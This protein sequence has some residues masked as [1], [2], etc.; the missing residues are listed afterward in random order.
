MTPRKKIIIGLALVFLIGLGVYVTWRTHNGSTDFDTY[1]YAGKDFL[2][3][4]SIYTPHAG[5]SPY[6][7]PPFFAAL[8]APLTVF[9]LEMAAALWYAMN[10]A[11]IFLTLF[12]CARMV[13]AGGHIKTAYGSVPLTAKILFIIT[14]SALFLDNISMLQVNILLA[15]LVLLGIYFFT[16]DNDRAAGLFLA[17]AIS[18][19]ITPVIFLLYFI[20]KRRFKLSAYVILWTAVFSL[21][22]PAAVTG[23]ENTLREI[24][25]WNESMLS[26]SIS[27]DPNPRMMI[28][29]FNPANQSVQAFLVRLLVENDFAI[30]DFKRIAHEY[31]LFLI[32]LNFSLTQRLA[33]YVSKAIVFILMIVTAFY[34]RRKTDDRRSSALNYEFA[35][36]FLA[37]LIANPILKTQQMIFL[38]F[39]LFLILSDIVRRP[40]NIG[41]FY[42]AYLAAMTL[43]LLHGMQIFKI[44]G[45]G[46]LSIVSL[47]FLVILAYRPLFQRI[48]GNER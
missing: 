3:G 2:S 21:G 32:N 42:F 16:A 22:V 24:V 7:Y 48:H 9:S 18:I 12:I 47:W 8:M 25:S 30:L 1:Y 36:I 10:I 23:V 40:K 27:A 17:M 29:M 33:L 45:F 37:S 34:C 6:I 46:A 35:L 13:S 20:L 38:I 14:L 19:K 41:P 31:P 28:T 5:V 26:S 39:P 43:Y 11:F 4:R 44:L 15:L